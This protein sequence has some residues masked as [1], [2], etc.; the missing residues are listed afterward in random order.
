MDKAK[1]IFLVEKK[2]NKKQ[3]G[4]SDSKNKKYIFNKSFNIIE[5]SHKI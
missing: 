1:N 3:R 2:E 4:K 5:E